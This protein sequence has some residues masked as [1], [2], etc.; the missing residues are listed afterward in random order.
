[1]LKLT[2]ASTVILFLIQLYAPT[3]EAI[4]CNPVH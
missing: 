2:E 4:V 3:V 1:M